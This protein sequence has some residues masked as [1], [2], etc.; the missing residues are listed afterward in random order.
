MH[1][2]SIT[3]FYLYTMTV[4]GLGEWTRLTWLI[5]DNSRTITPEQTEEVFSNFIQM[6]ITTL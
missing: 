5:F 6:S 3:D 4:H 1:T 2:I